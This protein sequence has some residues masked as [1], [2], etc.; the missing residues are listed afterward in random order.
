MTRVLIQLVTPIEG[1]PK[2][3][4]VTAYGIFPMPAIPRVH[5]QISLGAGAPVLRVRV[6]EWAVFN[7]AANSDPGAVGV[8]LHCTAP[9]EELG[10]D[11]EIHMYVELALPGFS[12]EVPE[13]IIE[14]SDR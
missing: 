7:L 2:I 6:V 13:E 10:S 1:H 5:D 4:S 14:F 8:L 11:K 9:Q 12:V 3:G